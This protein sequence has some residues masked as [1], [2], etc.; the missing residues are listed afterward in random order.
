MSET[1][2]RRGVLSM[3]VGGLSALWGLAVAGVAGAYLATPLRG[4][5][6]KKETLVGAASLAG[7]DFQAVRLRI[8]IDDGWHSRVQ[9]EL[10]Y[11]RAGDDGE[12]F[13]LSATCTHLGCTVKFNAEASEFQCPCH[14]GLFAPDG[15]VIKGPPPEPLR[16]LP[17]VIRDGNIYATMA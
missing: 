11:V 1:V 3:F 14:A 6:K 13:V 9:E 8:P 4:G 15:A 17:A 12:P 10:V 5:L 16:R 7:P 2:S